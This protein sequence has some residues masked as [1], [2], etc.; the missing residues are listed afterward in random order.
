KPET[1]VGI[2]FSAMREGQKLTISTLSNM[3]RCDVD[4][5]TII[6]VGNSTT[7]QA[8]DF[9]ITPRGYLDKYN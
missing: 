4:M 1:P 3:D 5:Q 2:V 8:G 9:M 6:I 7:F